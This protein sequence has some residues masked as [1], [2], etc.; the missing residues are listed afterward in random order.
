[1]NKLLLVARFE[2]LKRV[3]KKSFI[4]GTS[5]IPVLF[6][7][8][9]GVTV[10]IIE[11]NK[12]TTPVGLVDNSGIIVESSVQDSDED[13]IKFIPFQNYNSANNALREGD[14]QGFFVIP[15]A[16]PDELEVDLYYL[17]EYPDTDILSDFDSLIRSN[18]LPDGPDQLQSR[19]IEGSNLTVYSADG[20]RKFDNE[21]GIIAIIFPF[22]VAMFFIF[23]VMGASG[24]FLQSVTDEK[25]NRTMEIMITSISPWQLI[26]GKSLGLIG[27]ALTQLTIWLLSLLTA[28]GVALRIFPELQGV[29]L[30]L[31]ILILF[32]LFFLPSFALISAMMA[33]IGGIVTELQQGQQIAGILNLL[34]TFPFFL[35]S[36]VFA[37]PNSPLLI[38]LSYWPTTSFLTITLRWGLAIIPIWQILVSWF[39]LFL[40][41]IATVWIASRIFRF[42]MLNYGQRLSFKSIKTAFLTSETE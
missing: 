37:N 38:F 7:L 42:G 28:W 20:R 15:E 22:I 24:Y 39:I 36:V 6:G 21:F 40:S 8:I 5:L 1:L 32:I 11:R 41:V 31:D 16:Y 13:M 23:S 2:Y 27:V 10:L 19:I 14:I 33:A 25:E 26:S 34:F 29:K 18:I 12:N 17:D 30:P 3:G 9:I 4:I 35:S